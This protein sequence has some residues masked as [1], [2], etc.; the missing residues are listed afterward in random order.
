MTIDKCIDECEAIC[1]ALSKGCLGFDEKARD[2]YQSVITYLKKYKKITLDNREYQ[3][4]REYDLRNKRIY[5]LTPTGET[6]LNYLNLSTR[7]LNC[8]LRSGITSVEQLESINP[9]NLKKIRNLGKKSFNE[10]IEELSRY[11]QNKEENENDQK[12]V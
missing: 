5:D 8:L 2:F 7:S 3:R 11:H 6:S 4:Q 1:F 10:I 12:R 9:N